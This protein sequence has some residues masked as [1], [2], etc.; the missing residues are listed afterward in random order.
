MVIPLNLSLSS[1]FQVE[2]G[3]LLIILTIDEPSY[4]VKSSDKTFN[5]FFSHKLASIQAY[6]GLSLE[7]NYKKL[8]LTYGYNS[9]ILSTPAISFF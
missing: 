9:A 8:V 7:D 2:S 4:K 5:I 6:S 1:A 3:L